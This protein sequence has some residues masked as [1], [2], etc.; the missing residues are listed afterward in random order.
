MICMDC[1]MCGKQ[2][3]LMPSVINKW[4][5]CRGCGTIYCDSCGRSRLKGAGFMSQE[6]ICPRCGGK[7]K[8]I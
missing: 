3:G 1:S 8:L 4:H 5:Q 2:H 6:R 7:T